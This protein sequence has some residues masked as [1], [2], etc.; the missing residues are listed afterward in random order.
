VTR[1][2][3]ARIGQSAIAAEHAT[4]QVLKPLS[5]ISC[6]HHEGGAVVGAFTAS[7]RKMRRRQNQPL[8]SERLEQRITAE[9][10]KQNVRTHLLRCGRQRILEYHIADVE[11]L[12]NKTRAQRIPESSRRQRCLCQR[13]HGKT[14]RPHP[15]SG[16]VTSWARDGG[17]S[18]R[19]TPPLCCQFEVRLP[20][21]CGI[22]A[23]LAPGNWNETWSDQPLPGDLAVARNNEPATAGD[24]VIAVLA[25]D[26]RHL[27]PRRRGKASVQSV[28][29]QFSLH[30]EYR[31]RATGRQHA[32][33]ISTS[34]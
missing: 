2:I 9:L 15:K 3:H 5:R 33:A 14:C 29:V 16:R 20:S 22:I 8:I 28:E 34:I 23:F 30:R 32:V 26:A 1:Q 4:A 19:R 13:I 27:V 25:P 24:D 7:K 17:R 31:G 11:A 6:P 18:K 12:G 10:G 21:S